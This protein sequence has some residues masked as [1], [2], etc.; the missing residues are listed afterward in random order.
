M[1]SAPAFGTGLPG[2][3]QIP[4]RVKAW[5]REIDGAKI[6]DAARACEAAGFAW[7]TCS[8]HPAVPVSRAQVMGPTWFDAGSTLAFV[9]GVTTRIRLMPHVLVLPYRH[10]L[11]VAKQYGTLDYLSGGRV[12]MGVGSGHVKAEFKTLGADFETRGKVTD[13]YMRTLAAAWEHDVAQFDGEFASVRDMMVWPRPVQKPRPP[14]WV[15]GNSIAAVKR[16]ARFGDGW[17]PWELT[18]EDFAA[19]AAYARHLRHDAGRSHSFTL[20]APMSVAAD[21]VADPVLRD[22]TRWREAGAT[23]FHVGLAADSWPQYLDRIAWFGR[24]VIARIE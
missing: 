12:I 20:V 23:A 10:P 5:E 2:I 16:A 17:I 7:V 8:D 19:K 3:Q 15:G 21:A 6:L 18:P 24:A 14:F 9:A 1:P 11:V 22:V 4:S 13:E